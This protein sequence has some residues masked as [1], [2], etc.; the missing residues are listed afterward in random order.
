MPASLPAP[1]AALWRAVRPTIPGTGAPRRA[2]HF[3]DYAVGG[4]GAV[5]R[6]P[7]G[8]LALGRQGVL[9]ERLRDAVVTRRLIPESRESARRLLT[10]F[11]E[12]ERHGR[13]VG[14]YMTKVDGATMHHALEARAALDDCM[15]AAS[16]K[17]R[18][19]EYSSTAFSSDETKPVSLTSVIPPFAMRWKRLGWLVQHPLSWTAT[20]AVLLVGFLSCGVNFRFKSWRN[21]AKRPP[22]WRL[23]HPKRS[24]RPACAARSVRAG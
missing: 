18:A 24:G 15:S 6:A 9:G 19:D 11:L 14:E 12:Y 8:F 7:D 16:D 20:A 13:F 22:K 21:R 23:P 5:S 2:R 1:V 10:D 17:S 4:L 3:I